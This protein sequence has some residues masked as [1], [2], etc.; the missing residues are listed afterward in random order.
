M[1]LEAC[2]DDD[3]SLVH[4][5]A[6]VE[7]DPALT[8][9]VLR[10][11]NSASYGVGNAVGSVRAATMR[12]GA[13]T[14][15]NLTVTHIVQVMARKVD[16]GGFDTTQFWEH[17]LR[18]AATAHVLSESVGYEDAA[19]AFTAGLVQDLGV[20]V[21]AVTRPELGTELSRLAGLSVAERLDRERA[22]YGLTHAEVLEPIIQAWGV[23]AQMV[24]AIANHHLVGEASVDRR[25]RRL[26][27]ILHLA[28]AI[29]DLV[30]VTSTQALISEAR[31]LLA[32]VPSRRPVTLDEVIDTVATRMTEMAGPLQI[33]IAEQPTFEDLMAMANDVVERIS[34]EYEERTRRLEAMLEEK[35]QLAQELETRNATLQ[36]IA[37]VDSLTGALTRR[38]VTATVERYLAGELALG[39]PLTVLMVD[40]DHFKQVNDRFGHDAG[41]EVLRVVAARIKNAVRGHDVV[42]RMGGEEFCV[43]LP[44]CPAQ[45]GPVVAERVR[46]AIARDAVPLPRSGSLRVTASIGGAT[47]VV[48]PG[49]DFDDLVHRADVALYRAKSSGRNRVTWAPEEEVA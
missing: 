31:V 4:I 32:A 3:A 28:D 10:L 33:K 38:E 12:L 39:T 22:L 40:L 17:S 44:N 15:R 2:A 41:D 11:A 24:T 21:M 23:P 5:S 18:R 48:A 34:F 20:L 30:Q 8:A 26:C 6:L 13:R 9:H 45:L 27:E 49:L 25:T 14:I 19:E 29:S 35:E 47:T 1:I 42:G 43:L 46:E 36:T 7:R 16:C 37:A